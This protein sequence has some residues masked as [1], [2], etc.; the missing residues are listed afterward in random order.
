[1]SKRYDEITEVDKF[2][3]YHG[4][5]GK[6]TD[7]SGGGGGVASFTTRTKNP[8]HQHW[9]DMAVAREKERTTSTAKPQ[10]TAKP[11]TKITTIDNMKVGDK[12][13]YTTNDFDGRSDHTATVKE[14]HKDHIIADVKGVSD[15]V[16]IDNDII[17]DSIQ[18]TTR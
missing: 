3:P 13:T 10:S 5:D 18:L 2:N 4:K 1:M 16:W 7:G 9:A 6:F 15:H 11:G 14:K 12:F 8:E 17:G